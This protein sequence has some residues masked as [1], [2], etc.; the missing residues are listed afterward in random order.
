MAR[1]RSNF[2]DPVGLILRILRSGDAA[3]YAALTLRALETGAIPLDRALQPLERMK[4]ERA[5]RISHPVILVVGLPRSGTTLFYQTLCGATRV[6]YFSNLSG[7]FRRSTI[8]GT[9]LFG[10]RFDTPPRARF[11]SFYGRTSGFGGVN[12]GFHVWDRWLGSDRYAVTPVSADGERDMRRFFAAWTDAFAMPLATK[13]NRNTICFA[14][15]AAILEPC[16]VVLVR[17]D[18]LYV[19]QSLFIARQ[20]VQGDAAIGWGLG[21]NDVPAD[22]E[23]DPLETVT[24]QVHRLDAQVDAELDRMPPGRSAVVSYERFLSDPGGVLS[25]VAGRMQAIWPDCFPADA[26]DRQRLPSSFVSANRRQL[27]DREFRKLDAL[28]TDAFGADR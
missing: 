19:A 15:L 27:P 11:H 16:F 4:L 12:D 14:R 9:K 23:D 2:A 7:L 26:V 20:R 8:T 24:R 22:A 18:P 5:D 21:A 28:V 3:A 13:N 17:R 10:R 25:E 1:T 6:S